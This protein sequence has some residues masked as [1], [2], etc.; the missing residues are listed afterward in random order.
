[1]ESKQIKNFR[2]EIKKLREHVLLHANVI[3][4]TLFNAGDVSI[5]NLDISYDFIIVD[6]VSKSIE[7]DI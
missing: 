6:E 5:W 4:I 2:V 7:P 3:V 1:M